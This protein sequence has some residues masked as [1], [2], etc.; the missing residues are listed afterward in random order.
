MKIPVPQEVKRPKFV[1]LE[2]CKNCPTNNG[3]SDPE[4]KDIASISLRWKRLRHAFACAWR[5]AGYCSANYKELYH[6]YGN[7]KRSNK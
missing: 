3:P 2:C 4:S 7:W 5:P 1:W 6:G